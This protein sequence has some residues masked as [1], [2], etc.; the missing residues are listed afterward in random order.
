VIFIHGTAS[1]R[2]ASGTTATH[3]ASRG[4][5]VLS[6]DYPGLGLH[7]QLASTLDCD[8]PTTGEQDIPGDVMAQIDALNSPS[9]DVAFL[10]DRVDMKRLGISGHSQGACVSATL[11]NLPNV[12]VVIPLD[13]STDVAAG[14][15]LQSILF[16]SGMDDQVI[17]YTELGIGSIVC[18]LGSLTTETAYNDSPG[19]PKVKKRMVGIKGG[20][21]LVPTDLCQTNAQGKNAI[22]ESQADG[23]C[24]I[25]SAVIIGLPAL[26]D[27][28]TIDWKA[29]VEAVNVATTA[30]LEE[31]LHCLNR[32]KQF[33][34]LK[35]DVPLI[36][37]FRE[38][39][40]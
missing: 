16:L 28:G 18:P 35:T 25:D 14:S 9:G 33:A 1:F 20:G 11:G 19:P 39:V 13:G 27:C 7:D 30:A 36:G 12:K 37:D 3:W 26:F 2:I 21:H 31:T 8:L 24:G 5:V 4:F 38:S 22:Q 6:A 15:S 23:V 40:K 34:S 10:K 32:D 29:G 17:G